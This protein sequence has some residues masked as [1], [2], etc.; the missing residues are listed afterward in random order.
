MWSLL[1]TQFSRVGFDALG[2]KTVS[3]IIWLLLDIKTACL[4]FASKNG[5]GEKVKV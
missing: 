2:M 3:M 5:V 1:R 4:N